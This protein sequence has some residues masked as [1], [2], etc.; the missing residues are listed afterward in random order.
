VRV[1]LA[2]GPALIPKME[3]EDQNASSSNSDAAGYFRID[4]F[5]DCC[6]EFTS[7]DAGDN[8]CQCGGRE[9]R[10]RSPAQHGRR[11]REYDHKRHTEWHCSSRCA[12]AARSGESCRTAV[13][14]LAHCGNFRDRIRIECSRCLAERFAPQLF[15]NRVPGGKHDRLRR[16]RHN[17]AWMAMSSCQAPIPRT[18]LRR[19]ANVR[20]TIRSSRVLFER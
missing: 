17:P 5:R 15:A 20:Y 1:R 19:F 9:Q 16:N 3:C 14:S 18:D 11:C 6:G 13:A 4:S 2:R 8:E 10:S 7:A 12:T